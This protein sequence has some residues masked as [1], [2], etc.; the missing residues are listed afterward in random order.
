MRLDGNGFNRMVMGDSL[1]TLGNNAQRGGRKTF[2][3][4]IITN[5]TFIICLSFSLIKKK[6]L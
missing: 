6:T 3:Y 2:F 4:I 1:L 5:Y